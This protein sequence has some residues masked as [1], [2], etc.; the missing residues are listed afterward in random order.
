MYLTFPLKALWH[1]C[2]T[3]PIRP[4]S[5]FSTT[6]VA[7]PALQMP[8]EWPLD[9]SA[10]TSLMDSNLE[11]KEPVSKLGI[12]IHQGSL[13]HLRHHLSQAQSF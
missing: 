2:S 8:L 3:A 4:A 1:V 13:Q 11:E 12:G 7:A 6:T 5:Y 9:I 10:I